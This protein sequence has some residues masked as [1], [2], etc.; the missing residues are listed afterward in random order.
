M[1]VL[2]GVSSARLENGQL[3]DTLQ[4]P[5]QLRLLGGRQLVLRIASQQIIQPSLRRKSQFTFRQRF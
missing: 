3:I 1:L 4:K 2:Q 5:I